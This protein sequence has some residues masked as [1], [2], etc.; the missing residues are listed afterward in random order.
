M[1]QQPKRK[2]G[3]INNI[4][5]SIFSSLF[6]ANRPLPVKKIAQRTNIAWPTANQHVMKL[7][8]LGILDIVKSTRRTNVKITREMLEELRRR[9]IF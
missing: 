1:P 9:G 5:S 7:H 6:R 3:R 2:Q 4:D 8:K